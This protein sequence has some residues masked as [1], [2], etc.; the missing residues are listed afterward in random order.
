MSVCVKD[1]LTLHSEFSMNLFRLNNIL[2]ICTLNIDLIKFDIAILSNVAQD[3]LCLNKDKV[4][5][6]SN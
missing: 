4:R 3:Y 6:R 2:V 1:R 5:P